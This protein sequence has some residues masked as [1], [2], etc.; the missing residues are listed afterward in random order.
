MEPVTSRWATSLGQEE[1]L[2]LRANGAAMADTDIMR[3]SIN[4]DEDTLGQELV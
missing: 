4:G 1:L 3:A 2:Y